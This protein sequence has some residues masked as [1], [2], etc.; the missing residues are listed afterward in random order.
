MLVRLIANAVGAAECR[1]YEGA[2]N[3]DKSNR[4]LSGTSHP[5]LSA[6]D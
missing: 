6:A 4:A 3:K 5:I 1:K 2:K